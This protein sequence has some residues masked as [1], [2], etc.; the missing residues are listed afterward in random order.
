MSLDNFVVGNAFSKGVMPHV[1]SNCAIPAD[2]PHITTD[3]A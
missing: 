3:F 2:L 1:K